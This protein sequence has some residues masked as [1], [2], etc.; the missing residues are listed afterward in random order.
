MGEVPVKQEEKGLRKIL[1]EVRKVFASAPRAFG[2]V[3]NAS[4]WLTGVNLA[5]TIISAFFP[6]TVLQLTK[7][8]INR[9][10]TTVQ[11]S[12]RGPVDLHPL[13][14]LLG[15]LGAVWIAQRIA[16]TV[17]STLNNLLRFRVEQYSQT[18]IMRKCTELDVVFFE[19]PKN[20]DI[21]ENASTGAVTSAYIVV[22]QLFSLVRTSI[23]LATFVVALIGLHWLAMVVVAVTTVPQMFASS[24]FARKRWKMM[25]DRAEDSRLRFYISWLMTQ[26]DPAKEV[27]VFGLADNL[28]ARFMFF[29]RKF[30]HQEGGLE[31]QRETANLLLGLLGTAGALG[32]WA[33]IILRAVAK[34]GR[35]GFG[36]IVLYTQ[37]VSSCQGNLLSLFTQGG[38]IYEQTLFMNNLFTL[39]DLKPA[40]IEGSLHGPAGSDKRWGDLPAPTTIRQGIE[41]RNVSFRYPGQEHWVLHDVSFR[42]SPNES[43]ALVGRNGA[44]KTTLVKLLVRLYDPTEGEILLEGRNLREYD[45]DSL[46]QLFGVIFQ[47]FTRYMLTLRENVGFGD[48]AH[49]EDL[50]RVEKAATQA[51]AADIATR[52]PKQYETYLARQF[53]GAAEDLSGGEWQKVA[54]ARAY[55]RDCPVLILDEPT[56]S[57]DAFA[58]QE[59]YDTFGKAMQDRMVVFI[60]HRFSTV[61]IARHIIVLDEGKLVE[62]GTHE[63]LI[64]CNGLYAS[65]F[66][67][68]AERY[69]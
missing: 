36:D 22:W 17:S 65:M 27:R 39:L 11:L 69:R 58:E 6:I 35:I 24:Y 45:L 62:E 25:F 44:G 50:P 10:Q 3:W 37:A 8:T 64:A 18:L 14:V 46:R 47:D 51:G 48:V 41:F 59:V 54:L 53:M 61:R 43:V 29:C 26:R 60:S 4:P 49:V 28:V 63:K 38:Q 33:Y 23:T 34:V 15:L 31:R 16:D 1:A 30:F 32:V 2:L 68:Q 7:L 57:L 67:T 42:L 12:G 66:E 13:W 19:N 21:L 40:D 55:M 5:I 56:A 52:L 20:M 9:I